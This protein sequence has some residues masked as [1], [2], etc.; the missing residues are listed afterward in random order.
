MRKDS[1]FNEKAW[2]DRISTYKEG[3]RTLP[4]YQTQ[5]LTENR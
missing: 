5:K 4:F 2:E 1:P 3:N